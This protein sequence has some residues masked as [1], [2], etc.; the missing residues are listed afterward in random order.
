MTENFP[1]LMKAIKILSK[2]GD[3]KKSTPKYIIIRILKTKSKTM[4][5]T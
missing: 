4:E 2:I 3:L 5:R 1:N